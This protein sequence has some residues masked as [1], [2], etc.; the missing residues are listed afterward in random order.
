MP[1]DKVLAVVAHDKKNING[2]LNFI[3]IDDIGNGIV[4]TDVTADD[5]VDSLQAVR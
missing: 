5:I 2:K 4:S 1:A 3:L